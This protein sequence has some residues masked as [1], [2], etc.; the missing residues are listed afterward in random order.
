MSNN[1]GFYLLNGKHCVINTKC[2]V[3]RASVEPG[4]TIAKGDKITLQGFG[5]ADG[6]YKVKD[7]KNGTLSLEFINE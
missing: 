2:A 4:T 7:L 6:S 1:C 5:P 3:C